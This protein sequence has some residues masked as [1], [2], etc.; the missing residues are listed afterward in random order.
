MHE[1]GVEQIVEERQY[2]LPQWIDQAW[3]NPDFHKYDGE[4]AHRPAERF[5]GRIHL[6][7]PLKEPRVTAW[8]CGKLCWWP[9]NRIGWH[10][11]LQVMMCMSRGMAQ[12]T[13]ALREVDEENVAVQVDATDLYESP[14]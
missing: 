12:T 4:Y 14:D 2:G 5:K 9:P 7:T 6:W 10:G 3:L 13:I 1:L 11:F 8:Y